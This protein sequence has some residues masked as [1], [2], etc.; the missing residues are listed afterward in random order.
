M[1]I[2]YKTSQNERPALSNADALVSPAAQRGLFA[3]A[4]WWAVDWLAGDPAA[5]IPSRARSLA[6]VRINSHYDALGRS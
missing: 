5:V 6:Y 1:K 3:K 4:F 2:I